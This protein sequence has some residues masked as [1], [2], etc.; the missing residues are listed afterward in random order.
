LLAVKA[1]RADT[2]L[3]YRNFLFFI[4]RHSFGSVRCYDDDKP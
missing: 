2:Q 1:L 4:S 3:F